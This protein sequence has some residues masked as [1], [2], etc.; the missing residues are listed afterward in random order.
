MPAVRIHDYEPAPIKRE[1]A[2]RDLWTL[3]ADELMD[4][5]R[6]GD[7]TDRQLCLER[8]RRDGSLVSLLHRRGV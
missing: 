4:A 7:I 2:F 1:R 6:N 8:L 5:W 3:T